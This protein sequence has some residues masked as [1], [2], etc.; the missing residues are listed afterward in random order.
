M[1]VV[2]QFSR[3]AG[4]PQ[5]RLATHCDYESQRAGHADQR[6]AFGS[7]YMSFSPSGLRKGLRVADF[8]RRKRVRCSS[9]RNKRRGQVASSR[10]TQKAETEAIKESYDKI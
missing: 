1:T 4:Q 7:V 3:L 2:G 10:V 8:R 9:E 5:I 6:A